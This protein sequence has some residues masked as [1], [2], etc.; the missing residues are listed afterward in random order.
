MLD[1]QTFSPRTIKTLTLNT[2]KDKKNT[3]ASQGKI[4]IVTLSQSSFVRYS[5]RSL[6]SC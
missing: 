6:T 4:E 5:C 2:A 3:K 1:V